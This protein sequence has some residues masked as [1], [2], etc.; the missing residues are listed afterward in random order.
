MD[1]NKLMA[2]ID[3]A[4]EQSKALDDFVEDQRAVSGAVRARDWPRLQ[5]ALEKAVASAELVAMREAA[6]HDAWADFLDDIGE[7]PD[8]TVFRA[9]LA[10]P[11]DYR[12]VLNDTYRALRL[13]ALRAR[14]ENDALSGFVGEASSTLRQAI[15]TLFPDRKGRMY[16]KSGK[17]QSVRSGALILD[18]AL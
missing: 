1:T 2:F 5:K 16:G 14:I 4:T 9:S 11:L 15:E 17:P 7:A 6:R 3:R 18:T 10:L 12:A 8:A 13:S